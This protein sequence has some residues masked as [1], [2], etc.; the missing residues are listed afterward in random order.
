M[1]IDELKLSVRSYNCL[2]NGA[3]IRTVDEL[4][5]KTPKNLLRIPNFGNVSLWEVQRIL[6]AKGLHLA[7]REND[8]I[9]ITKEAWFEFCH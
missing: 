8:P 2:Y 1:H 3:N 7:L 6:K 5:K 4:M 9:P